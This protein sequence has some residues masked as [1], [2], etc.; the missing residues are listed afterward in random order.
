MI[1]VTCALVLFVCHPILFAV[2]LRIYEA[3]FL[4]G[5]RTRAKI[6]HYPTQLS[7]NA[8]IIIIVQ[9]PLFVC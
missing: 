8:H 3:I 4:K 1:I 6:I 5:K 2:Y 7:Q 9:Y